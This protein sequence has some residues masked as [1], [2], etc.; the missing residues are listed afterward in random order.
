M[1]I[2]TLNGTYRP[3]FNMTTNLLIIYLVL[4]VVTSGIE[5]FVIFFFG[6]HVLGRDLTLNESFGLSLLANLASI[7]LSIPMWV[8]FGVGGY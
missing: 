4:E 6:K 2:T 3:P 7:A 1:N 5:G 8:M